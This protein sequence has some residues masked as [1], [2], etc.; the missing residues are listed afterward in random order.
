ML[1]NPYPSKIDSADP[2]GWKLQTDIDPKDKALITSLRPYKGTI[3]LVINNLLYNI[4]NDIR[5]LGITAYCPDGE[6]ILEFLT[7]PRKLSV[8]QF[9]KFIERCPSVS[10]AEAVSS[11]I[12]VDNGRAS[13]RET[14][15]E[16]ATNAADAKSGA[17]KRV[18]RNTKQGGKKKTSKSEQNTSE[19]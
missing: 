13:V 17:T 11:G 12:F 7:Q 14:I 8:D 16:L 9:D 3:Q 4:A 1:K 2:S 18:K 19:S 15:T 10:T 6:D 5:S